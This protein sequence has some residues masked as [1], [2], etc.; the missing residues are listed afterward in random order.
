MARKVSGPSRNGS[1]A[2]VVQAMDSAIH[3]INHYPLDTSIDFASVYPLWI[4][5]YPVD[6]AIHRLNNSG[7]MFWGNLFRLWRD[8]TDPLIIAWMQTKNISGYITKSCQFIRGKT[9][10]NNDHNQVFWARETEHPQ[11]T[12]F[13]LRKPL[14]SNLVLVIAV[15]GLPY[16]TR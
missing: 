8:I 16:Q 1:Q 7:Q 10:N 13:F 4:V 6:S 11:Q 3:R 2:P 15:S 9:L 5:I 12:F 14:V